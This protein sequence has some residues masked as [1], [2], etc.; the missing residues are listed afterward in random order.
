MDSAIVASIGSIGGS[1]GKVTGR[2]SGLEAW[3]RF[4]FGD[5]QIR[6]ASNRSPYNLLSASTLDPRP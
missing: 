4:E 6:F 5:D 1:M 3:G 2:R